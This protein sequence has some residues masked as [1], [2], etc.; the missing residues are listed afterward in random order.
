MSEIRAIVKDQGP[1]RVLRST[2]EL[3]QTLAEAAAQAQAAKLLN[4]V[5][6]SAPNGDQLSLVVGGDETVLG[7]NHGHGNPPYYAS[8]GEAQGDEPVLTAYAGLV[9]HT[10]FPRRWVVPMS[11]GRQAAIEFLSTCALPAS[12]QWVAV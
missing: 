4:I 3:D 10:E 12:V 1:E 9:H 11:T 6:L 2:A 7:F 8:A 5:F